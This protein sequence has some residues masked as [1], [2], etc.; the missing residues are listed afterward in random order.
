M[1]SARS[2]RTSIYYSLGWLWFAAN[3]KWT[4][5]YGRTRS[6]FQNKQQVSLSVLSPWIGRST[7]QVHFRYFYIFSLHVS[8]SWLVFIISQF[9]TFCVTN[10][11]L[12]QNVIPLYN[13]W[14][15]M[16]VTIVSNISC[17]DKWL[18]YLIFQYMY[19]LIPTVKRDAA[20]SRYLV[21]SLKQDEI[22]EILVQIMEIL[23]D[24]RVPLDMPNYSSLKT[25]KSNPLEPQKINDLLPFYGLFILTRVCI[26]TAKSPCN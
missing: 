17:M 22:M 15:F 19:I 16:K 6:T 8:T 7:R 9:D 13:A 5:D 1:A 11:V 26:I 20:D 14:H 18:H 23:I 4:Q 25:S 3:S 2:K 24:R 12:Q 21:L 10:T